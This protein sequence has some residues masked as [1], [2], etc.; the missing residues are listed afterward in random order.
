MSNP[1]PII[2][3][4]EFALSPALIGTNPI[5]YSTSLGAKLYASA[6]KELQNDKFDLESEGLVPFLTKLEAR[7]KEQGWDYIMEIP[8]D[9]NYPHDNLKNLI[10]AYG[11]RSMEQVQEHALTYIT[12][13]SRCAQE[14]FALYNCLMNSLSIEGTS[15]VSIWKDQYTIN[16][17]SSGPCLLKVI[18]R[19]SSIDTNATTR[20]IRQKLSSLE[21]YMP[22]IGHDITKFNMYVKDLLRQLT[23]RGETTQ[24][25]LVNLFKGYAATSDQVF[26]RYIE[27]KEEEY[28][29]GYKMTSN[30]LMKL[31]SK[32]L[33][34]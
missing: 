6:T 7:Q 20:H 3:T 19:E 17:I 18:I 31:A 33:R 16:N 25:L 28:D 8:S 22:T 4:P 12:N 2:V 9:S 15:K 23:A 10:E 1:N 32:D 26:V 13:P 5:D 14:S 21:K 34:S 11:E 24:D 30:E 27:K 29:D